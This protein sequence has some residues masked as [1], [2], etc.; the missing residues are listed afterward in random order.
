MTQKTAD[1]PVFDNTKFL[2]DNYTGQ[3]ISLHND[4]VGKDTRSFKFNQ[5]L[6]YEP[7]YQVN[8]DHKAYKV[9]PSDLEVVDRLTK[10]LQNNT[11]TN[12]QI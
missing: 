9:D 10:K 12:F 2:F 3:P 11:L 8:Q 7:G 6:V 4:Q 5:K 1:Q